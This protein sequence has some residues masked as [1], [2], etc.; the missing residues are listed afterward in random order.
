MMTLGC[1]ELDELSS[2]LLNITIEDPDI[3]GEQ[4]GACSPPVE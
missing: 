2:A 4:D 1:L 3:L